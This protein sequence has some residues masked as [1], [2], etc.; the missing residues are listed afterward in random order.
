[1]MQL[2]P[3]LNFNGQCA[4]AF[5][6]YKKCLG[7][8]MEMTTHGDSPI[9]KEAPPEWHSRILHVR[10]TVGDAVLMGS[11]RPPDQE[12]ETKG[13]YVSL[14]IRDLAEAKRIFTALAKNGTVEM[15][16]GETFWAAG[17][18]MFV[19]Q[20]GTPWMINCERAA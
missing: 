11:G 12:G 14:V 17:F 18:G 20:F 2:I 7:G 4:A 3:Y 16:F 10:L 15:P 9:A 8:T 1:M 13:A 5:K 19:D 6:F